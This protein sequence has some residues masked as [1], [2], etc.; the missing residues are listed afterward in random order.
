MFLLTQDR[1]AITR[2]HRAL[3]RGILP[4]QFELDIHHYE[5]LRSLAAKLRTLDTAELPRTVIRHMADAV[6]MLQAA[7]ANLAVAAWERVRASEL[8]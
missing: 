7:L 2:Q 1:E 8:S 5:A 4:A 3:Y 6:H